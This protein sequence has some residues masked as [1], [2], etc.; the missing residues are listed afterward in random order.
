MPPPCPAR[1]KMRYSRAP[2]PVR[3]SGG[4]AVTRPEA[5][6]TC[7]CRFGKVEGPPEAFIA[8][9]KMGGD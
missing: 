3:G 5:G 8:V 2:T 9:L 6:K 7:Q 4:G 1:V